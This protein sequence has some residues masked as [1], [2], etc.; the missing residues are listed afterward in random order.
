MEKDPT[1]KHTTPERLTNKKENAGEI[2]PAESALRIAEDVLT[3]LVGEGERG[4]AVSPDL[5]I[6][7]QE[8]VAFARAQVRDLTENLQNAER[9]AHAHYEA[10]VK[11]P[12]THLLNRRGFA[13]ALTTKIER[14]KASPADKLYAFYI[15]L[16]KF[17]FINDTYGHEA[18]DRYLQ[19]VSAHVLKALRPDDTF[20]RL[21]GDEFS[22]L[23]FIRHKETGDVSGE[24]EADTQAAQIAARIQDALARARAEFNEE[25]Q[26]KFPALPYANDTGSVGYVFYDPQT[27]LGADAFLSLADQEMYRKKKG[28]APS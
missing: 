14:T 11:D 18:G 28:E 6:L 22:A 3:R 24:G 27:A 12:L 21:G 8:Q 5:L 9:A 25:M 4:R 1:P 20:A 15:D 13:E 2:T 19:G 17:K 7:V 10:A 23:C 16:D 26:E